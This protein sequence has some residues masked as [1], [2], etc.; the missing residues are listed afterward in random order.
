MRLAQAQAE[1]ARA[2]LFPSISLTGGAGTSGSELENLVDGDFQVWNLGA[3]L[4]APLFSGGAL[5]A[6]EDRAVADRDK[7]L[8]A[9]ASQAL[10]AFAE[11]D[12]ALTGEALLKAQLTELTSWREK[13][14][15]TESLLANQSRRGSAATAQVLSASVARIQA[16]LQ[17]L[18]VRRELFTNRVD[19]YLALGGGFEI[20]PEPES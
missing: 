2:A 4:L 14:V 7:A 8:F 5:E 17:L 16:D 12:S 6:A 13:L 11:V 20:T 15:A 19:L 10:V 3:N 1:V 18:A 9:F